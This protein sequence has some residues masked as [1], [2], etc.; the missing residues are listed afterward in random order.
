MTYEDFMA[1]G[2][3]TLMERFGTAVA[4]L[5]Y[6]A[7]AGPGADVEALKRTALKAVQTLAAASQRA[8]DHLEVH[9]EAS[10]ITKLIHRAIVQGGVPGA[11]DATQ[12]AADA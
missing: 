1:R 11:P 7:A 5:A 2:P 12:G 10:S 4:V 9:A 8:G 6:L 3:E